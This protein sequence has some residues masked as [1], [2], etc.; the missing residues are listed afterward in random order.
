MTGFVIVSRRARLQ[1][2]R[3][4]FARTFVAGLALAVSVAFSGGIGTVG[5]QGSDPCVLLTPDDIESSV[6]KSSVDAGVARSFPDHGYTFCQY[7][8]GE[9]TGRFRLDVA[10]TEPSR[11]FPGMSPDQI[12]QQL[13]QSVRTGTEDTLIPDIGD[14]AVFKPA[15]PLF[16]TGTSLIKGRILQVHLDGVF[17]GEMKDQLIQ[18]LKTAASRL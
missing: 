4:G 5:A 8:W 7:T 13:V 3:N 1:C 10:L 9:A 11:M 15:S 2:R 17:A 14:A 6:A 18:L 12:K 16:A